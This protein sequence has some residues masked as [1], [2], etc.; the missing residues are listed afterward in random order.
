MEQVAR[1]QK[2]IPEVTKQFS[3]LTIS[4]MLGWPPTQLSQDYL[5]FSIK[6]PVFWAK[7]DIWSLCCDEEKVAWRYQAPLFMRF[8]RQECWSVSPLPPPRDL[9][10][11]GMEAMS[12][13]SLLHCRGFFTA[14]PPGSPCVFTNAVC[15][16]FRIILSHR[17]V[18]LSWGPP[19]THLV[20]LPSSLNSLVLF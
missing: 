15:H 16:V 12:P 11:P 9:P 10:G 7:L 8:F 3:V 14:E 20:S 13:A 2:E 19:V 4:S 1:T 6:S 5:D 17:I 18:S